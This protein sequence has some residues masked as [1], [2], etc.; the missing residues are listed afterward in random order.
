MKSRQWQKVSLT[1]IVFVVIGMLFIWAFM[2]RRAE[3]APDEE[4]EHPVK[5]EVGVSVVHGETVLT[6]HKDTQATIGIKTAALESATRQKEFKA[7]GTVLSFDALSGLRNRYVAAKARLESASASYIKS[8]KIYERRRQLFGERTISWEALQGIEAARQTDGANLSSAKAAF[9][10]VSS[11]IRQQ[12][13]PVLAKW[14]YENSPE[15]NRLSSQE[16]VLIQVTLPSNVM[17][18]SPPE[19]ARVETASRAIVSAKFVSQAPRTDPRIQGQSFYYVAPALE[20]G[21]LPG[22]NVTAY[23]AAGP[24]LEGMVVP[25]SAVVWVK[26]AA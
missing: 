16:D 8:S 12:W 1:V 3:S 26:G 9:Q 23:L 14:V 13:G 5:S 22:M 7:Y 18:K 25:S 10:V 6:I 15:F 4:A 19:T 2:Q 21:L 20:A 11:Q 17:I 24:K